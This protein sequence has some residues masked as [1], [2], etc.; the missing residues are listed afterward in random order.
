MHV[1]MEQVKGQRTKTGVF[2][3]WSSFVLC[4]LSW[5]SFVFSS[6]ACFPPIY[7]IISLSFS[8]WYLYLAS[9]KFTHTHTQMYQCYEN[10]L[11]NECMIHKILYLQWKSWTNGIF[12]QLL[13]TYHPS[14]HSEETSATT[15]NIFHFLISRLEFIHKLLIHRHLLEHRKKDTS[16]PFIVLDLLRINYISNI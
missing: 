1:V 6:L 9:S 7:D 3:S 8:P 14:F 10:Q 2:L 15:I 12:V 11:G 5:S 4:Y 16:N 13:D